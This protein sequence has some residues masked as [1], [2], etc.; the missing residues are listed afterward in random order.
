M[1]KQYSKNRDVTEIRLYLE[2][3]E[4]VLPGLEK[5]IVEPDAGGEPL[6]LRFFDESMTG[7]GGGW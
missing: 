3:M 5:F 4:R 2:T 1:V 7:K 6:D